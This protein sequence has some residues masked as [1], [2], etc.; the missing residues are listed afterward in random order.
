MTYRCLHEDT[1]SVDLV[2]HA[3]ELFSDSTGLAVNPNKCKV[4]YGN[5]KENTNHEMRN[6]TYF[7]EGPLPFRYLGVPLTNRK[8][9]VAH[10]L[11]LV[12]KIIARIKH[13]S[14]NLLSFA[15]RMKFIKSVIFAITNYWMQCISLTK[16]MI[17]LMEEI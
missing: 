3:F 11:I 8:L 12:E 17:K 2:M 13:W 6:L 1:M 14:V 7:N 16:K 10:Y 15:G 9:F 4:Y 5:M